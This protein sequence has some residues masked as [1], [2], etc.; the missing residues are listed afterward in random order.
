MAGAEE[1]SGYFVSAVEKIG[2]SSR[3][4]AGFTGRQA[5]LLLSGLVELS[6]FASLAARN[7]RLLLREDF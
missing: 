7:G 1:G 5:A 6:V 4:P 2:T 3:R